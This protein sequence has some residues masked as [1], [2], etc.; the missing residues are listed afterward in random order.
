MAISGYQGGSSVSVFT[1]ADRKTTFLRTGAGPMDAAF[2]AEL[3][4]AMN[5]D[6]SR[7]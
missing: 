1:V 4:L 6:A 3:F 5:D 2:A 7:S